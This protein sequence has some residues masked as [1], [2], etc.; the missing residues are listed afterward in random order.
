MS[1]DGTCRECKRRREV[2]GVSRHG[3]GTYRR[4]GR[5]YWSSLCAD[6][7]LGIAARIT[8]DE[9]GR[10]NGGSPWDKVGIVR[11]AA[12]LEYD[13]E[14]WHCLHE[15]CEQTG[16]RNPEEHYRHWRSTHAGEAYRA[17][18]ADR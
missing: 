3:G 2:H 14:G 1:H 8:Y 4:G 9:H 16:T 11:L 5:N 12:R 10:L 15:G 13:P 18:W 7:V 6:C 17:R